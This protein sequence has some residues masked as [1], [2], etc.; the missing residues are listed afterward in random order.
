MKAKLFILASSVSALLTFSCSGEKNEDEI[1]VT[2]D[3]TETTQENL[4]SNYET[5]F[6]VPSPGE[7]IS[8]I[9][10]VG[11]KDASKLSLLNPTENLSKYTDNKSKSINFGIYSTD[12]SYCSIFNMGAEA[13][14]YF[15]VVKQL[16]DQLGLSSTIKPDMLARIEKNIDNTDSLSAI[17]D[18]LYF[19][20][21]EILEEGKQGQTLALVVAGGWIESI[22]LAVNMVDKYQSNNPVIQRI[23]DQKYTLENLIEFLK[24]HESQS[25][26]VKQ[27]REDMEN[28]MT[29]FNLLKEEKVNDTKLNTKNN[30]IGGGVNL[31]IDEKIFNEIKNKIVTIR[32]KY[33]QN[34]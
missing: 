20:S 13:I 23:A 18:D 26:D 4:P 17:T 3:S 19:S 16:G 21:F 8:F 32:N 34:Q 15:K 1:T 2:K 14:K 12:L 6:Q 31:I 33:I 11:K 25:E 30:M 24:K 10:S 5:F 28:L 22:Y 29:S 27:V 7:M 9:K